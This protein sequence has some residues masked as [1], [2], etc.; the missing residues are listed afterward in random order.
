MSMLAVAGLAQLALQLAYDLHAAK[1]LCGKRI[2][3]TCL[4]RWTAP[5]NQG[6]LNCLRLCPQTL[7]S[8]HALWPVLLLQDTGGR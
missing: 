7:R 2:A 8:R 5:G 4:L 3:W 1:P 6:H